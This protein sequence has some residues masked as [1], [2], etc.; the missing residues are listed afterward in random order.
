MAP[1]NSKITNLPLRPTTTAMLLRRGFHVTSEIQLSKQSGGI[2]N[3]AA[4]LGCSLSVAASIFREV[5]Q[6]KS[7]LENGTT[8][9]ENPSLNKLDNITNQVV[10]PSQSEK[11]THGSQNIYEFNN[12]SGISAADLLRLQRKKSTRPIVTF[13]QSIDTLLGG[14]FA[15][16]EVTEVVGVPGVGKTQLA[17][18]LCVD[19]SIP[20]PHGGVEGESVYI[21]SEGSFAPERCYDMAQSLVEHIRSSAKRRI[22]RYQQGRNNHNDGNQSMTQE[23]PE[24][25]TSE[26]ILSGIHVFRVYDEAAQMATIKSLYQF[27]S[28][29]KNVGKPVK[30]V[31]IDSIAFHYRV[32]NFSMKFF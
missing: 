3:F 22:A 32:R 8:R 5:E 16:S 13:C 29:R 27:L 2:A 21:D 14:G 30:I 18:Q 15:T 17:I 31:I 6:A 28:K 11:K 9:I 26:S 4:E 7:L 20:K 12:T 23:I 1:S 24:S 19:A 25:Y 10:N